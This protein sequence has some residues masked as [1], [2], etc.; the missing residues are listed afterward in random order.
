MDEADRTARQI[1]LDQAIRSTAGE[2]P[3]DIISRA[4]TFYEFLTRQ[5]AVKK[6]RKK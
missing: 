5:P 3:S 4:Q 1:A 6:V 2:M